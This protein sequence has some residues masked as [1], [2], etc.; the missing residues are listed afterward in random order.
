MGAE[1]GGNEGAV[2]EVIMLREKDS[3]TAGKGVRRGAGGGYGRRSSRGRGDKEN[4]LFPMKV[5]ANIVGDIELTGS[6]ERDNVLEKG[7][8]GERRKRRERK[9]KQMRNESK[10]LII[11]SV[12]PE[13]TSFA[14]SGILYTKLYAISG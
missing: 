9:D 2:D 14:L 5:A 4:G 12:P 10:C 3:C 6:E 1:V 7:K 8:G 13:P 11:F